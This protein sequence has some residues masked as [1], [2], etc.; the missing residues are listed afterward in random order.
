MIAYSAEWVEWIRRWDECAGLQG[1]NRMLGW[2][3]MIRVLLANGGKKCPWRVV[4]RFGSLLY[5]ALNRS[6]ERSDFFGNQTER[7]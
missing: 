1:Q 7:S 4:D 2:M 3:M 6:K 5:C